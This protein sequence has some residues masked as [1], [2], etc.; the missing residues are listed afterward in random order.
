MPIVCSLIRRCKPRVLLFQPLSIRDKALARGPASHVHPRAGFVHSQVAVTEEGEMLIGNALWAVVALKHNSVTNQQA[1][2]PLTCNHSAHSWRQTWD[3]SHETERE[4]ERRSVHNFLL[5]GYKLCGSEVWTR[6]SW[7][8]KMQMRWQK[9]VWL[10]WGLSASIT[11]SLHTAALV[12]VS[13]GLDGERTRLQLVLLGGEW[14]CYMCCY[15][16]Q[17]TEV[18]PVMQPVMTW[19]GVSVL[20]VHKGVNPGHPLCVCVCVFSPRLQRGICLGGALP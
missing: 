5:A 3:F 9:W 4:R 16:A 17:C 10:L 20:S 6:F 1:P 2:W 15:P 19:D 13:Q 18:S 14:G 12:S 7:L 11:V 8:T